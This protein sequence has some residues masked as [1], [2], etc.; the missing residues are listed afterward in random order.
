MVEYMGTSRLSRLIAKNPSR[1]DLSGR[2]IFCG[3]STD[4]GFPAEFSDSFTNANIGSGGD[5]LCEYCHHINTAEIPG[6]KQSAGKLYRANMWYATE[7]GVG[8]IRFPKKEGAEPA[9]DLSAIFTLPEKTPRGALV[10]PPGLP[11]AI[12]LTRTWKKAG[13][14]M[15]LRANGGIATSREYF[16]VGLDYEVI[17]VD[18]HRLISDLDIIDRLRKDPAK[19][20]K[21]LLTK[22]EL[23]SGKIGAWS[24]ARMIDAGMDVAAIA[25]D[26]RH[27][28][29]DPG[30]SLAV[31]IS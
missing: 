21:V 29:N 14:Q 8:V 10:H 25:A 22:G 12:Y 13:W 19:P 15:M 9:R 5:V 6:A 7:E 23:E 20:G 2:C 4:H 18:R 24:V 11:F 30:W 16:P 1:G 28:A 31:Y 3:E 17:Y 26:L 27:R